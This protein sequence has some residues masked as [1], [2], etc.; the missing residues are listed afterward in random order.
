MEAS[1]G[2]PQEVPLFVTMEGSVHRFHAIRHRLDSLA[3]GNWWT[4]ALVPH[5]RI[6]DAET[7][8][9]LICVADLHRLPEMEGFEERELRDSDMQ[10]SH[11]SVDAGLIADNLYPFAAVKDLAA[12]FQ[13][14]N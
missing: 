13:I 12:L 2:N 5:E 1:A 4:R 7:R 9:Q 3:S 11:S 10:K 8:V 6:A 14:C